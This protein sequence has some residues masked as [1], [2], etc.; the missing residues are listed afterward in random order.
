[1]QVTLAAAGS[2]LIRA[3]GYYFN[4]AAPTDLIVDVLITVSGSEPINTAPTVDAGADVQQFPSVTT[5]TVKA[6]IMDADAGDRHT[7]TIDWGDGTKG[8][9]TV[10]GL[11]ASGSHDYAMSGTWI[12]TVS[13]TDAA[14]ES[15]SDS[16]N[17][18]ISA[19]H[20]KPEAGSLPGIEPPHGKPAP[21]TLPGKGRG[22]PA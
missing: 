21:G 18:S 17:V 14:G 11:I 8:A 7:A 20:G 13:V 9:L 19:P 3:Q 1:M 10:D 12:A 4:G 16:L 15:A 2:F 22:P 5:V 6:A